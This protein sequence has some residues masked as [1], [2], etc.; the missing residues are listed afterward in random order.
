MGAKWYIN[1]KYEHK[2]N[3]FLDVENCMK[4]LVDTKL[5]ERGMIAF[6]G[7][8]AGG[9]VAGNVINRNAYNKETGEGYVSVV[10]AQVPFIDPIYDTID[11][12]VPWTAFEWFEWGRTSDKKILNA[13]VSYSPYLNVP[14]HLPSVMVFGGL[15]DPRVPYWEPTKWVARMRYMSKSKNKILLRIKESGHFSASDDLVEAYSFILNE[16]EFID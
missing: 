5:T 1:G 14:K 6:L 11:P 16:M 9:L 2:N 10:I 15:S 8:S 7:R 12:L 3:T 13:M 4:H